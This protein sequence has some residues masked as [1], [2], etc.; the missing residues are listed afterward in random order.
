MVKGT[1][2]LTRLDYPDPDVIRVGD[3]YYI[4]STTMYFMPGAVIL[5]SYDLINWEYCSHVYDKLEDTPRQNLDGANA[6]G[7]GMWAPVIRYHDGVFHVVFVANDTHKT[8][9][10]TATDIKGPWKKSYIEGFYHDTS[11]LFDDDG[12]IYLMHGNRNIRVTELKEDMSGP[13]PG[14]IDKVVIED[15][16]GPFLGYEGCHLYKI[17][18]KYYAFFI[19]AAR[20]RWLRIEAAFMSDSIE[21]PWEGRD[22]IAEYFDGT[23]GLA[24][25]GI[26]D[27]PDGKYYGV[28]FGDR[29]A[30]GR[31]PN[32]VPM[33]FDEKGFPVFEKA[34]KEIETESTRPGYEY[35]PLYVTD[36]FDSDKLNGA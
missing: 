31:I 36:S 5:R 2:P 25:G 1:N 9:H 28:I 21:G 18:G 19:H 20:D 15:A 27:T 4:C 8:Y 24:Q 16:P 22:V 7:N 12:R 35:S 14:G 11:L 6:Y 34:T 17:N 23:T 10:Y 26:V 33:H 29:G 13:K 3:T 30:V 32:L